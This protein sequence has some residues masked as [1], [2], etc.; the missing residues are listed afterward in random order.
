MF[1]IFYKHRLSVT[2]CDRLIFRLLPVS[3]YLCGSSLVCVSIVN[4][5]RV[6]SS[7]F[8][9]SLVFC[10]LDICF[11]L[12]FQIL[13]HFFF[14]CLLCI[15]WLEALQKDD[16][17]CEVIKGIKPLSVLQTIQEFHSDLPFCLL[18]VTQLA[19]DLLLKEDRT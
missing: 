18:L 9:I 15:Y 2:S 5:S 17:F 6:F 19:S 11:D 4:A 10:A 13:L 1:H 16:C 7:L 12:F 8:C 3:F 14:L